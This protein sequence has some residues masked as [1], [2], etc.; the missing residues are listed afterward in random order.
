MD[1]I[2][3]TGG[4]AVLRS[5]QEAKAVTIDDFYDELARSAGVRTPILPERVIFYAA[6]SEYKLY[7]THQA[8]AAKRIKVRLNGLPTREYSLSLPHVYFMHLYYNAALDSIYVFCSGGPVHETTDMLYRL[9]LKNIHGDGLVCI[10]DDLKFDIAGRF[11]EKIGKTEDFFWD[12][13]FNSDLDSAFSSA[14]PDV[15]RD[16]DPLAK[17]E[18]MSSE[19][20]FDPAKIHWKRNRTLNETVNI[21]LEG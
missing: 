4:R 6:R 15:F 2:L 8:P 13:L 1:E 14:L 20:G 18:Q 17:W 12:S 19:P 9:P 21:L 10:G 16:D 11:G 3:I 5:V 7:M